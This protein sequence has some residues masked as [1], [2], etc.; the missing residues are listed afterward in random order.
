MSEIDMDKLSLEWLLNIQVE[1]SDSNCL[2][3]TGINVE[4]Q[5]LG[6]N[7]EVTQYI[8]CIKMIR[9]DENTQ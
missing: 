5:S 4:S 9:L 6:M 7:L 3:R 2:Y 8:D 1:W